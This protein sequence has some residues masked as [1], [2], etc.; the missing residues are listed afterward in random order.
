[1]VYYSKNK[2]EMERLF[3]VCSG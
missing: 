2:L 1:M 3:I